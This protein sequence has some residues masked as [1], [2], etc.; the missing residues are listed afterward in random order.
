MKPLAALRGL[1]FRAKTVLGIALIEAILLALLIGLSLEYLAT[2][3]A[4]AIAERARSTAD[5]FAI[6]AKDAVLSDDLAT[7]ETLAEEAMRNPDLASLQVW[8]QG[9]RRLVERGTP[10]PGSA[11]QAEAPIREAGLDFG[12]IEIGLSTV[13]QDALVARLRGRLLALAALEIALVAL[14]SLLLGGYLTRSLKEL[15][16]AAGRISPASLAA[17]GVFQPVP[18]RGGDELAAT[19]RAFNRMA[20]G[21]KASYAALDRAR[22][23]AEA[24]AAEARAASLEAERANAAKSRFLAHMSH[25]LRTPLNA[26]IGTLDLARD[27]ALPAE[28]QAQLDMADEAGHALLE[29]INT[30]LDLSK[31]ESGETLLH[32]EPIDPAALVES[33]ADLVRPLARQKGLDLEVRLGAGLPQAV[34]ADPLRLRQILVNLAGNAVKFT[35]AGRVTL[36]LDTQCSGEPCQRLRFAVEDTGIGIPAEHL[37]GLFDEFSQVHE[38]RRRNTGGTGLGLAIS[39][40]LVQRMGG[41]IR[42]D[43]TPGQGSR[44]AFEAVFETALDAARP[45]AERRQPSCQVA[46]PEAPLDLPVLLVDD[47]LTNRRIAE[48]V[49]SK[50]GYRVLSVA[51]GIEALEAVCAGPVGCVLMDL[52]MPGMDGLEATRHIRAMR[53]PTGAVPIIAMTAHALIEEQARCEAAGMD[54]FV[55]KPFRRADLL[56]VV[57]RWHGARR[58]VATDMPVVVA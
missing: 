33:A 24:A 19:A 16:L 22:E 23:Q 15:E 51:S 18:V 7:L 37:A 38:G 31:I 52:S 48:A 56:E 50:A 55:T 43:S 5:L 8:G 41:Q 44:F 26:I 58:G 10:T 12:R 17:D 14:F 35:D 49:L 34:L 13:G 53:S 30:V 27:W 3:K 45:A 32:P 57:A 46:G 42:V 2:T 29:L 54:D 9:A 39:Q 6:L 4:E 11:L 40:R 47:V 21:L 25:E 1:S 36:A 28:Q 20:E